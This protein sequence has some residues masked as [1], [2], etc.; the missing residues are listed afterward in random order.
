[1]KLNTYSILF[2][3]LIVFFSYEVNQKQCA[4]VTHMVYNIWFS[5]VVILC[6]V[7]IWHQTRQTLKTFKTQKT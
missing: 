7:F 4:Y 3:I 6:T 2:Y 1:M 5:W